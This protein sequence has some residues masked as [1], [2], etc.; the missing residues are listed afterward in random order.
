[1]YPGFLGTPAPLRSD[2]TVLLEIVIGI[3]L[4]FGA[5]FARSGRYRLHA[6]CQSLL[7]LLN[8]VL[9]G[10]VMMPSFNQQVLPRIPARLG[11]P[12]VAIATAHAAMGITAECL[13]VYILLSAGTTWL[14]ASLRL[15]RYRPWMRATLAIW[16]LAL[17]LGLATYGRWY[18]P[19]FFH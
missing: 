9:I 18:V 3:G 1:L 5:L 17:L 11:K 19:S 14:P 13:A 2:L 8:L 16:W 7:V 12:F 6:W 15:Q 4:G 10:V